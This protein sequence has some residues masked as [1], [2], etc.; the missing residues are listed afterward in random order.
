MDGDHEGPLKE[1]GRREQLAPDAHH[2]RRRQAVAVAFDQPA[3]DGRLAR[4]D[5][6]ARR[7][8]ALDRADSLD[9]LGA[10]HQEFVHLIVDAVDVTAQ[11]IEGIRSGSHGLRRVEMR[12]R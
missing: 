5:V 3:Q 6:H 11:R 12:A 4:R 10:T 1:R 8:L 7:L 9:H 2:H